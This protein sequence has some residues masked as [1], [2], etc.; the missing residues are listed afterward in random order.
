MLITENMS[1][2]LH[3]FRHIFLTKQF[4]LGGGATHYFTYYRSFRNVAKYVQ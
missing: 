2:L 4:V 1:T 3:V